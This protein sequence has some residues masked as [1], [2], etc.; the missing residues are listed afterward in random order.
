MILLLGLITVLL[1]VIA[2]ELALIQTNASKITEEHAT[3]LREIAGHTERTARPL[4]EQDQLDGMAE[5]EDRRWRASLEE[6]AQG[7]ACDK[8]GL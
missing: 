2:Y 4:Y 1:A 8:S 7:S 6:L 3:L 5:R